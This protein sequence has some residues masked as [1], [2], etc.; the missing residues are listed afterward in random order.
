VTF[1]KVPDCPFIVVGAPEEV[2][3]DTRETWELLDWRRPFRE[4]EAYDNWCA[5]IQ[6]GAAGKF[7][8]LLNLLKYF[9]PLNCG[10]PLPNIP[11]GQRS[12]NLPLLL[13]P[14]PSRHIMNWIC[15]E[16]IRIKVFFLTLQCEKSSN[17]N[18]FGLAFPYGQEI[19]PTLLRHQRRSSKT[20]GGGLE[21]FGR[22]CLDF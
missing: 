13:M 3:S 11:T 22:R 17:S 7:L 15:S 6:G 12:L 21:I 16:I 20:A 4:C 10:V 18:P 19:G 5:A 8:F 14:L 9:I 2:R 1:N